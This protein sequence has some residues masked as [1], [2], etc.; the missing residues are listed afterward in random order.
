MK[1]I[2]L[3]SLCVLTT[4]VVVAQDKSA[5]EIIRLADDTRRGES[6]YTEGKMTI[7]RPK[8]ERSYSMKSWEKGDDLSLIKI[9]A[10]AKNAGQGYLKIEKDLW[11]WIPSI[12]RLIKMS[13]SVMGQ[14]WMG[15]D[16]TNDDMVRQISIVDDYSHKLLGEEIV[17]EDDCWKIELIPHYDAAVVW[18]KSIFWVSKAHYGVVRVENYDE[19]NELVQL[20][21]SYDFKKFG[22]RIIPLKTEVEPVNEKGKKTILEISNAKFDQKIDD[23]FFSQQNLKNR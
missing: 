11:N 3:L 6:S 19:D 22:S 16:F 18:S 1:R 2:L 10:P 4:L 5:T 12:D 13:A 23:S 15:S 8:W 20:V 9:T 17:R 21:N 14:S 7:V